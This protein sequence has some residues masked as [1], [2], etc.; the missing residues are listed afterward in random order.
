LGGPPNNW[1]AAVVD[2]NLKQLPESHAYEV[3]AFDKASIMKYFFPDWMF[4][5][6]ANSYCYTGAENLV[7]SDSDKEG[8]AKV[9][10]RAPARIRSTSELRSQALEEAAKVRSLPPAAQQHFREE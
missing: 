10:P 2:F 9:Y 1:P 3:G 5:S 6:G 4:V 8:A 7:L